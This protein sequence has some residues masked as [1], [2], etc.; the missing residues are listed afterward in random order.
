V[1]SIF[2][3]RKVAFTIIARRFSLLH[4]CARNSCR[5]HEPI[6]QSRPRSRN[7]LCDVSPSEWRPGQSDA[8]HSSDS[9]KTV[10]GGPKSED[11][12]N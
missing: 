2:R 5:S 9:D 8:A 6:W 7:Q 3:R 1:L 10:Q 12:P 4:Y 11:R